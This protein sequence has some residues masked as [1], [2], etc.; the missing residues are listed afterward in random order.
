MS[1]W[2]QQKFNDI[3]SAI[4]NAEN[5]INNSNDG[6]YVLVDTNKIDDDDMPMC[7]TPEEYE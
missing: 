4:R 7:I 5:K 3:V 2:N 1:E 6:N